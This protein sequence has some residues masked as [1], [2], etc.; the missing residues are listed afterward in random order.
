MARSDME[1]FPSTIEDLFGLKGKVALVLGGGVGHGESC[2]KWLAFA[3]CDVIVADIVPERAA[4]VAADIR[5]M[6][7]RAYV[8]VGDMCEPCEVDKILPMAEA[9]LGGIDILVSVIGE[10]GW[11]GFLDMTVEDWHRDQRRNLDYVFYCCQWVA[12]SM[13]RRKSGGA[14]CAIAS[15]DGLQSSAMHAAYGAAKAGVISLVKSMAMELAPHGIRANAVAPGTIKTP[16]MVARTSAEAMDERA[17]RMGIPLGRAGVPDEVAHAVLYLVS[18]LARYV[19]GVA[20][21]VDGGWLSTRLDIARL[22]AK[23]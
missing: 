15:V 6:G 10:G 22:S 12:R 18:D 5:A 11:F 9:E 2:A 21:P 7:R 19:T 4:H 13:V 20:L 1:T 16:R 3:G 17:R 23:S 14:I 8:A